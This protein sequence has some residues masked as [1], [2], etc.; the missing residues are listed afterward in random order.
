MP[1]SHM[2]HRPKI[3]S[4]TMTLEASEKA[5]E[6]KVAFI[7]PKNAGKST[8]INALLK[9]K[10][11][12]VGIG[13]A[14]ASVNS[15]RIFT[16]AN[17]EPQPDTQNDD[18]VSTL[19]FNSSTYIADDSESVWTVIPENLRTATEIQKVISELPNTTSYEI[20]ELIFD[21]ELPEGL[22]DMRNDTSI[23]LIDIP[24]MNSIDCFF[25]CKSMAYFRRKSHTFDCVVFV[26]DA[27][28]P[29]MQQA[30]LLKDVKTIL[31]AQKAEVPVIVVCNK[32]DDS[33]NPDIAP[34]VWEAMTL[35]QQEFRKLCK[36]LLKFLLSTF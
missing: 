23:V 24:G 4:T 2:T 21:V 31:A 12:P 32:V 14:T 33:N 34:I 26:F 9:D 6:I 11:A 8:L 25:E 18:A 13:G 20:E 19:S 17:S 22:W 36:F 29:M 35:S 3:L 28:Q 30:S 16:K 7:G 5:F 10:F 15:F 1:L 27:L